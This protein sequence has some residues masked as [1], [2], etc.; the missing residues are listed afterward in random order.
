MP[1]S[2]ARAPQAGEHGL[3]KKGEVILTIA[4]VQPESVEEAV[5]LLQ[6]AD[7]QPELGAAMMTIT[8]VDS[9]PHALNLGSS[10]RS[11]ISGFFSPRGSKRS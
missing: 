7:A 3:L 2:A 4:D 1:S 11:S 9:R 10:G 5:K 8:L 6:K